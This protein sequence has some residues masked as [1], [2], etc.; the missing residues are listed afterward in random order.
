MT[1]KYRSGTVI[2][3][4]PPPQGK[5]SVSRAEGE[6]LSQMTLNAQVGLDLVLRPAAYPSPPTGFSW[7]PDVG[8]LWQRYSG[9]ISGREPVAS[10]AY[11]SLTV[12]EALAGGRRN[13][14]ASLAISQDVLD[15]LGRLSSSIG[16]DNTARKRAETPRPHTNQ[17]EGWMLAAVRALIKRLG[18][19]AHNPG[20]ALPELT[21]SDLPQ[22]P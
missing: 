14:P 9:C 7:S 11:F 5:S 22:L 1:F 10:M 20:A 19:L 16:D 12:V 8:A 17:E 3:R 13:A 18:E 4:N 6:L 2:D 15:T 21:M